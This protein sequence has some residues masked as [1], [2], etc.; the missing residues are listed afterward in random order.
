MDKVMRCAAEGEC[1]QD[2]DFAEDDALEVELLASA[3]SMFGEAHVLLAED[4]AGEQVRILE[5]GEGFQSA[6]YVGERWADPVFAYF[7]AFDALLPAA[8]FD[9]EGKGAGADA[10][11]GPEGGACADRDAGDCVREPAFRA[12]MLGAGGCALPKHILKSC[13]HTQVVA[14]EVDPEIMQLAKR[15]FFASKAKS[16]F[17]ERFRFV[18][19]DA[20]EF[21]NQSVEG[22][23]AAQAGAV[24]QPWAL[25]HRYHAIANDVFAGIEVPSSLSGD[26][27]LC[28]VKSCLEPGG[29]YGVNVVVDPEAGYGEMFALV[30]RLQRHFTYVETVDASDEEFGEW[31]NF[32]VAASDEPLNIPGAIP[33]PESSDAKL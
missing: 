9:A 24:T 10:V 8:A 26:E 3:R 27:G 17:G 19:A 25:P 1:V 33:L 29:R 20:V 11:L 6:S 4:E 5:V 21:L 30:E 13:P 15:W 32:L 22:E 16:Q 12:L 2:D 31:E 7:R 28:L 18:C 23:C 14:V